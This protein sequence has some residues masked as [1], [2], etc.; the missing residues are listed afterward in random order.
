[1]ASMQAVRL[2]EYGGPEVLRLEEAPRP[3]PAAGEVLVR[4]HGAGINPI[5]SKVRAGRAR[6][7]IPH[8]LPLV[9]G[10]DVSGTIEWM[11][12]SVRGFEHGDEVFTR[13]DVRRE[14][15]YAEYVTV[16]AEDL[17]RKPRTV[18]H[19]HAAA[20]PLA[21]LT[22]WQ[23]LFEP[24][25][26]ALAAGQTVLVHGAAGGVGH[27]AVQLA[28][29]R[30]ARVVA[31][32]SQGNEGFLR[33]LGADVFVDHTS[34]RFESV[35]RDVDVVLD[36]VGG[37]T[38]G[39]SWAVLR[40]GGV[41]VTTMALEMPDV[42]RQRGLR[43]S[44]VL[45]RTVAPQL[46]ELGQLIDTQVVRPVLSRILPLGQARRAH[47]LIEAGHVRGKLVLDVIG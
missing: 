26:A 15:A 18:D 39:R 6:S 25:N 47:E 12:P 20:V 45:T 22:A 10:W 36:T 3:D 11:G 14:G 7:W 19:L 46:V 17:A 28:K 32:G 42:A 1:M 29:W 38:Q 34:V 24:T 8:T 23:A 13:L 35:A 4:V 31:T 33:E 27:F 37:E 44:Q 41:L 9:P 16:P 21:G 30:Q 5:D 43:G 40:P 2:H